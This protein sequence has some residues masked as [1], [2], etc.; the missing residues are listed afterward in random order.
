MS[1]LE[2]SKLRGA[3]FV[4]AAVITLFLSVPAAWAAPKVIASIVPV[5][6]LVAG[7]MDGVGEPQLLLSGQNSEHQ[8]SYSPEQ[9][10]ALGEADVVFII[11]HGLEL[12]LG[13]LSGSEAVKGK[14][15]TALS[16]VPGLTL[17]A[18]REGG[19]WEKDDHGHAEDHE[20]DEHDD[21]GPGKAAFD[22]H[23]WLD[24]EN[25][26]LVVAAI[27]AELSKADAA[28]AVRYEA[29]AKALTAEI[30]ALTAEI[31]AALAPVKDKPYVVFH[32]AYQYF[33]KRFGLSPAGSISD[34]AATAPSAK[35]L[36]EVRQKLKETD[37]QCV[38]REPQFSDQAVGIVIEGSGATAGLLDP[39][40]ADLA[41]G[42]TAYRKLLLNLASGFKACL[43][44]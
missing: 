38:F 22:P 17:H 20:D 28:N 6:A 37:A 11:G 23:L 27:A 8:A 29:N 15:F 3:H 34:V 40:G 5:H 18:I 4:A 7:V 24:P 44:G 41:P 30:D 19:A 9:I 39:V 10:K 1:V 25:A 31:S 32:D 13:E 36:L 43:G 35:R 21:P 14:T 26:K 12:K 33:E 16:G 42:K 2:P